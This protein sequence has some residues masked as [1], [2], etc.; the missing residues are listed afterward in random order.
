MGTT[1]FYFWELFGV[2][3][4]KTIIINWLKKPSTNTKNQS[5]HTHRLILH[6]NEQEQKTLAINNIKKQHIARRECH[7]NE[8]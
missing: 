5:E 4:A 7:K 1:F 6:E 8:T 3:G 2:K